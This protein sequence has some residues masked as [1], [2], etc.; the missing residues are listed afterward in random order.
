VRSASLFGILLTIVLYVYIEQLTIYGP[1]GFLA[2]LAAL[3]LAPSAS[4]RQVML[5]IAALSLGTALALGMALLFYEGTLAH[6]YEVVTKYA[7]AAHDWWTYYHA[8]LLGRE[9]DF[10][11][12]LT[13]R[14]QGSFLHIAYSAFSL[15][16]SA[17]MGAAGLYHLLPTAGWPVLLAAAYKVLL[18]GFAIVLFGGAVHT[19]VRYLR[20][21]PLEPSS[22]MLIACAAAMLG[23]VA[24]LCMGQGWSAGKALSMA[25]PLLFV[26]LAAPLLLPGVA[27][28][29]ARAASIVFV[30]VQLGLG[31]ARPIAAAD[32]SGGGFIG[33]PF[34]RHQ[35]TPQK[36]DQDWQYDAWSAALLRCRHVAI[37]VENKFLNRLVTIAATD[38]RVSWSAVRRD[39]SPRDSI[40]SVRPELIDQADCL[41]TATQMKAGP[42]QRLIWLGA[43]RS[44]LDYLEGHRSELEL[45]PRTPSGVR[46]TGLHPRESYGG[47]SLQW[48][49]AEARFEVPNDPASPPR[50]LTLELWPVVLD[51]VA[52]LSVTV[53][54]RP[55]FGDTIPAARMEWPLEGV[56]AGETVSIELQVTPL[57]RAPNDPRE[58]GVPLKSLLLS[59]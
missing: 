59:R 50:T 12:Y 24:I 47:S 2:A 29:Y 39:M 34:G 22:T 57:Q 44:A 8:H 14:R 9:T 46:T 43:S 20:A 56:A 11:S 52:K 31:I 58:L 28:I 30:L 35:A 41:A 10:L 6:A 54:G 25:S 19:V 16:I 21:R 23:P 42:G 13:G 27:T 40:G 48:T 7:V 53:D 37:D 32:S 51:P 3:A 45:A 1:A 55:L 18:Y 33:F 5:S 15:P 17:A 36:A 26:L 38:L 4:R 49:S